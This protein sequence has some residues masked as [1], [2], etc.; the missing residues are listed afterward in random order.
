MF[1]L[2]AQSLVR[3]SY[4]SP[5]ET[6]EVN[7]MGTVNL[8]EAV[9]NIPSIKAVVNITTDKCYDNREWVWPYREDEVLGG[10]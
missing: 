10:E 7:V 4:Q 5:I 2:A 1:H 3:Y 9:R 8:L 6:Y